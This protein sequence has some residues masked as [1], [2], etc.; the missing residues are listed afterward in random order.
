MKSE[1][2]EA[3]SSDRQR[4]HEGRVE[5]ALPSAQYLVRL[6]DGRAV[7]AMVARESRAVVVKVQPGDRVELT[8]YPYDP[9]RGSI[10]RKLS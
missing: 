7:R 5:K 3:G 8:L 1:G 6:E 2:D 4:G 9:T 10:L